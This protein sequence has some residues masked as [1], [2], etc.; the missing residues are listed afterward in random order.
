MSKNNFEKAESSLRWLR[1]SEFD[2]AAEIKQMIE[3]QKLQETQG[4]RVLFGDKTNRKTFFLVI[5]LFVGFQLSGIHAVMYYAS[6]IFADAQVDIEPDLATIAVG[7][8]IVVA[9]F[10]SS[11]LMDKAG[12][13]ALLL[14]S[15]A[16]CFICFIIMGTYLQVQ[17]SRPDLVDS[18]RILPVI[19][20]CIFAFTNSIG[21]GPVAY[22]MVGELFRQNVKGIAA[23]FAMTTNFTL[24]LTVAL[25]FPLLSESFGSQVTFFVFSG[26]IAVSFLFVLFF[27]PETKGKSFEEIQ[28]MLSK[29]K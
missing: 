10:L 23:G 20:L 24:S 7:S 19:V 22:V 18:I 11:F 8:F 29:R 14:G 13:R 28:D 9:S 12:R 5:G 6:S 1:G 3:F 25:I 26:F 21:I 27:I 2:T 16:I 17:A 4:M 15:N